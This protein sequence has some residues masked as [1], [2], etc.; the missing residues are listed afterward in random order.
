[1]KKIAAASRLGARQYWL[2]RN[3]Q[4]FGQTTP[5]VLPRLLVDVSAIIKHDAQTGIQRVV[6]AIWSELRRRDGL[7][8]QLLPVYATSSRGYCYAPIDF[9]DRPAKRLECEPVRARVG[10]VFLG[11]DLSANFLP[12]YRRQIRAWRSNGATVHIVV[13]DL[14]P[15]LRPDWFSGA[16]KVNFT[17]WFE[18]LAEDADQAICIS[19]QVSRDL[20]E[21]LHGTAGE[22]RLSIAN[23]QMG[24][25]ISASRPTTGMCEKI[26]SLL[27]RLQF[28][29]AILMVG[30]VEPRKG[31]DTAIAAF[32]HLWSTRGSD[33][34]DLVIVGKPGWKTTTLQQRIRSHAEHGRRLYWLEQ[35]SD[36][37]LCRLY[38]SCAGVFMASRGEGFGLPL[39]EAAM[40]GRSVLARDIPVF[41]EQEL[42]NVTYFEDDCPS[43]LGA[44][45]MDLAVDR[46]N[47]ATVGTSLPSWSECAE[48]LLVHLKLAD[49]PK[50]EAKPILRSAS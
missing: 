20:R 26:E 47:S 36:E 38:E 39:I 6:R 4:A 11:L 8:Y 23:M 34:P 24:G 49:A 7:R 21:R 42:P 15:I 31:Y 25:D 13:Y 22:W 32:E 5:T 35:V 50:I 29:S 41:R 16:T 27:G 1:M 40:H 33:A 19:K 28:R 48:G 18:A 44:Q 14:L 45:L 12:K 2:W 9:L 17:R 30:T 10:D 37:A 3:R 43:A 46:P